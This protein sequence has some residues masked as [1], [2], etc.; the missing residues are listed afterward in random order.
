MKDI[1]EN[2]VDYYFKRIF[3]WFTFDRRLAFFVTFICGMLL[4]FNQYSQLLLTTD[5]IGLGASGYNLSIW[6]I[7]IGR[8]LMGLLAPILKLGINSILF[9][10]IIVF[11]TQGII[12]IHLNEILKIKSK[13]LI[14]LN[15]LILVGI[16]YITNVMLFQVY[17]FNIA[18]LF[19]ILSAKYLYKNTKKDYII[20]S[21]FLIL[22]LG[23]YQSDIAV[24]LTLIV[25]QYFMDY[26][27]RN[28]KLKDIFL[29]LINVMSIFIISIVIY[30]I[31]S[32]VF[33]IVFN[34]TSADYGGFSKIG[35][36]IIESLP[37]RIKKC[38]LDFYQYFIFSGNKENYTLN[39]INNQYYHLNI[40]N[41]IMFALFFINMIL[42]LKKKKQSD[43]K[44]IVL[45]IFLLI[46]PILLN[47]I[48]LAMDIYFKFNI[49]MSA[50]YVLPILF[51]SSTIEHIVENKC[52]N[53]KTIKRIYIYVEIFVLVFIS[54]VYAYMGDATYISIKKNYSNFY[55]TFYSVIERIEEDKDYVK[56]MPVYFAGVDSLDWESN[57]EIYT[58]SNLNRIGVVGT[59]SEAVLPTFLKEEFNFE[60]KIV[61]E[62][63]LINNLEFQQ[64]KKWPDKN[65]IKVINDIMVVKFSDLYVK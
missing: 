65:S 9:N 24:T 14:V 39:L 19:S 64:M 21:V 30:Y 16:P 46:L 40:V 10:T 61:N 22:T 57:L 13:V 45:M 1:K 54:Y 15:S 41:I 50:M 2:N 27:I 3:N 7:R 28:E 35:T 48:E 53:N 23:I 20:G 8:W 56:G 11:I 34:V 4:H 59:V 32:Q 51:Y 17:E 33:L 5:A 38:Y 63:E 44:L 58:I 18:F 36:N 37:F 31:I 52:L 47:I 26:M 42:I 60:Y 49:T 6:L 12:S 25:Y 55:N 29:K 43:L 62:N